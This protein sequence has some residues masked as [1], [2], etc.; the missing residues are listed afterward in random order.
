[1]V[2]GKIYVVGGNDGSHSL[3]SVEI[4]HQESDS[5]TIGPALTTPRANVGLAVLGKNLFAV[6]GFSGK[7]FLSTIEYLNED[8]DSEW[9]AFVPAQSQ[10]ITEKVREKRLSDEL[11]AKTTENGTNGVNGIEKGSN[12]SCE[13]GDACSNGVNGQP[14]HVSKIGLV[15]AQ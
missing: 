12:G 7:H 10:V 13:N 3:A 5:W 11:E 1:M 9:C 4:Y 6:G 2:T 15:A 14:K 8:E